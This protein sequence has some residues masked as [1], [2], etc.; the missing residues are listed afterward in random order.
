MGVGVLETKEQHVRELDAVALLS[1]D[2]LRPTI[3]FMCHLPGRK[4]SQIISTVIHM[5]TW[6]I[7]VLCYI[8]W[9]SPDI[10][11]FFKV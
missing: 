6:E 8:C 11:Q 10:T 4:L 1:M 9:G 2:V 7:A 5:I 3:S